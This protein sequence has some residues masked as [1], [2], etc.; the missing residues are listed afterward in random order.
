MR[1]NRILVAAG[2]LTLLVGA[3][4][5]DS[6]TPLETVQ[7]ASV[8]TAGSKTASIAMTITGGQGALKDVTFNGAY[9]FD[10]KLMSF[11]MDASKLG[12]PGATGNIEAVTPRVQ[13]LAEPV[14]RG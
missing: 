7:A 2:S 12:I 3:C 14:R 13:L 11:T 6:A 8:A 9:D 5:S 1:L 4:G 10:R